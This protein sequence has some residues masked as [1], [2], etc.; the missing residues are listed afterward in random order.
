M[1]S[2]RLDQLKRSLNA[3]EHLDIISQCEIVAE[4]MA[5]RAMYMENYEG[6]ALFLGVSDNKVYQMNYIHYNLI[7]SLKEWFRKSK[8]KC[9]TTFLVSRLTPSEQEEWLKNTKNR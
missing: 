3:G 7:P 1:L 4:A 2:E 6:L 8:Y 9:H 5:P